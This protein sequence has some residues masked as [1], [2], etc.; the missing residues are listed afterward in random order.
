MSASANAG[1]DFCAC[2]KV[3]TA[4]FAGRRSFHFATLAEEC[5]DSGRAARLG[6]LSKWAECGFLPCF[7]HGHVHA[8]CK[9]GIE[10]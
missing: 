1:A 9:A 8:A 6:E 3:Y 2:K 5:A 7:V 4:L 10:R